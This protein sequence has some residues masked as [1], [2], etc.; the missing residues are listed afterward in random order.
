MPSHKNGERFLMSVVLG[1][2]LMLL[3]LSAIATAP[4]TEDTTLIMGVFPRRNMVETIALFTPM[5]EYLAQQL[6]RPV[7]LESARDLETFWRN[8]SDKRYDIVHCNQYQYVKAHK[9][10]GYEAILKNE[11]F[12]RSTMTGTIST[13]AGHGIHSL[14]DLRGKVILFGGGREA[15]QSYIV[16]TL[17]L[18][19]AGLKVGDYVEKFALNPQNAV[20]ALAVGQVDFIGVGDNTVRESSGNGNNVVRLATSPP[21][22]QLPWAVRAGMPKPL[23]IEIRNALMRLR[24][25]TEGR[26]ILRSAQLTGFGTATDAD[27]DPH[28]QIVYRVLRE[29]Y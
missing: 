26:A 25:S 14:Q 16:P 21:Y 5:A 29:R 8:I 27:Y 22:A 1:L 10:L 4:A 24:S 28:R 9:Q 20:L 11:K 6:H 17:L 7:R 19:Q 23:R 15:M 18:R 3:A 2:A 13:R 12:G